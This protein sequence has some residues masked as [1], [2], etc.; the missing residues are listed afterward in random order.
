MK[1]LV[2]M[3]MCTDLLQFWNCYYTVIISTNDNYNNM[4]DYNV[5]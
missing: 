4:V 3:Y 5:F 2:Y 1:C